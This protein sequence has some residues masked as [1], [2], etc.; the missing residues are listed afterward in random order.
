MFSKIAYCR[1]HNMIQDSKPNVDSLKN[2]LQVV[3]VIL[4]SVL[5]ISI[6]LL[7]L[8][9]PVS[10][11]ALTHHLAVPKLYLKH[12]GVYEIPDILFSYYPMNL[13]LL[14][15]IPLYFNNDIIPKFI[16]FSFALLAAGLIFFYLK[17]RIDTL[18]AFFGVLF[19][20]SIPVIVKLSITVYVDLGLIFFSTASLLYLFKWIETHFKIKYLLISAFW[21]GLA[22]GTKYNGLIT[23][24]LLTLFIPIIYSRGTTGHVDLGELR[25]PNSIKFDRRNGK[26]STQLKSMGYAVV[27]FIVSLIVFSPWMIRNYLWT[28]NPV[29][30]LYNTYFSPPDDKSYSEIIADRVFESSPSQKNLNHFSLRSLMYNESWWQIALIP[31]RI[32]FEG[33]D[34]TPQYFDGKLNP[35]LFFLPFFAFIGLKRHSAMIRIEKKILLAFSILFILLVFSLIDMRIRWIA[36]AIPPLII[37][38]MFGLNDVYA[39]MTDQFSERVRNICTAMVSLIAVLLVALNANYLLEQY[40]YVDPISYISGRVG[41]DDYIERF[42]KEH[43]TILFANRNLSEKDQILGLFLGK[44][45]YYSDRKIIFDEGFLLDVLKRSKSP[46][47][48]QIHLRKR[49]I[50]HLFIRYDLFNQWQIDNFDKREKERVANFFHNDLNLLFSKN[51]YGLFELKGS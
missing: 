49:G 45:R 42:R 41:R 14:Y 16:H 40:R 46:K 22:L 27:F 47:E 3:L 18:Y 8:V 23:F 1:K 29:Y 13:E 31:I 44:R 12:G 9:P 6:I 43:P 51:N 21:C 39:W 11:D 17:K 34:G 37:L 35:L 48:V 19:F 2:F 15:M 24:F 4:L 38:S 33:Q 30:P 26:P 50:T 10:K 25:K 7:S 5:I 28:N 36:P 20:L 32:F